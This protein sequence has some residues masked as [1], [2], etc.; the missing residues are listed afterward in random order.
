VGRAGKY[1]DKP[2]TRDEFKKVVEEALE[3]LVVTA[4]QRLDKK[5][6]R[7]YC[8]SG[9]GTME[10][11]PG[12]TVEFL[13]NWVFVDEDHIYPCVDLFLDEL[14][15]DGRLRFRAY[16]AGFKPCAY[17]SQNWGGH[18]SGNVGPFKLGC[19][20]FVEKLGG[21]LYSAPGKPAP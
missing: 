17:G 1:F 18:D 13:T 16:R 11:V 19:N 20:S 21:K 6:P 7:Q 15:P 8:L 12:D 4:E 9:F 14:L 3:K 5:F 10:V 2:M